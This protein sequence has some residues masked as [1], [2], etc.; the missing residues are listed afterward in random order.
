M[1]FDTGNF[2]FRAASCCKVEVV[3]GGA[4]VRLPL[5]F[6]TSRTQ[7]SAPVHAS[8]NAR[9]S[10]GVAKRWF[11]SARSIGDVPDTSAS[12]PIC[13]WLLVPCSNKN[14][15]VTRY[16]AVLLNCALSRSRSTIRR[17]ATDCTR[18]ADKPVVT[19]YSIQHTARLL[20]IHKVV[21]DVP[22]LLNSPLNGGLGN[23][24]KDNAFRVFFV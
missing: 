2:N 8:K 1:V 14:S 13:S 19:Y 11:N 5:F 21:I 22:R 17:T 20:C 4:G 10:S 18:P 16:C 9:A 6:C 24:V 3:K 23:L 15:A 12:D 7:N